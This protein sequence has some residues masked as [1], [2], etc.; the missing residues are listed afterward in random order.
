AVDVIDRIGADAHH[1]AG[2]EA[3][4]GVCHTGRVYERRTADVDGCTRPENG[5]RAESGER[6]VSSLTLLAATGTSAAF[7][8]RARTVSVRSGRPSVRMLPRRE[9]PTS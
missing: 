2:R 5:R 3:S 6:R 8:D 4:R 7:S 1:I 9:H